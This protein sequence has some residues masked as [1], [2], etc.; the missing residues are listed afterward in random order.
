[1]HWNTYRKNDRANRDL[2]VEII[3]NV[4]FF[5]EGWGTSDDKDMDVGACPVLVAVDDAMV[6]IGEFSYD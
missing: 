1:M 3:T 5:T 2:Y 6:T 4:R